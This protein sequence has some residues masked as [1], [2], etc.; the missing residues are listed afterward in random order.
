MAII[1]IFLRWRVY[2]FNIKYLLEISKQRMCRSDYIDTQLSSSGSSNPPPLSS[3]FNISC[4]LI[5][6]AGYVILATLF[7]TISVRFRNNINDL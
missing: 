1:G 5:I 6:S 7:I 2:R 3:D 4:F